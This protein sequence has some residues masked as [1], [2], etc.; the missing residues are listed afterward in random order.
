MDIDR[1]RDEL[2][3]RLI[4]LREERGRA[5]VTGTQFD[6]GTIAAVEVELAALAD[7]E[8]EMG[9]QQ[10]RAAADAERERLAKIRAQLA[11]TEARRLAAIGRMEAAT[12]ALGAAIKDFETE[13]GATR[14]LLRA[15][16]EPTIALR[17]S[18]YVSQ[19]AAGVLRSGGQRRWGAIEWG[20]G[21]TIAARGQ[22]PWAV[23]CALPEST[24][25]D[26]K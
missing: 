4:S 19:L 1:R 22:D 11:E 15:L 8:A 18:D 6:A 7:A 25:G 20:D 21:G 23:Q 10:A 13:T 2:E 3:E 24:I 17:D 5:V 14:G 12:R 9:R 26:A 16:G